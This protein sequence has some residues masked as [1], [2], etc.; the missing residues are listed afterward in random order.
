M[1][2]VEET[3]NL[4]ERF[5]PMV[6][7]KHLCMDSGVTVAKVRGKLHFRMPRVIALNK[8]SN[9]PNDNHIPTGGGRQPRE[10]SRPN[11]IAYLVYVRG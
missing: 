1:V 9:E 11:L 4:M 3:L 6:I 5:L 7:P 2:G 10:H 8:A